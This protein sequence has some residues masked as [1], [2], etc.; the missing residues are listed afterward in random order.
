MANVEEVDGVWLAM[1][2]I[3]AM[4]CDLGNNLVLVYELPYF[5]K[6]EDNFFLGIR[7]HT[8]FRA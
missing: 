4:E 6:K 2:D 5:L 7:R 3:Y 8:Q 1:I